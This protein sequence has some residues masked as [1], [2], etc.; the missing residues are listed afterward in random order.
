MWPVFHF[1]AGK[2]Q[3]NCWSLCAAFFLPPPGYERDELELGFVTATLLSGDQTQKRSR[4]LC[5]VG[6]VTTFSSVCKSSG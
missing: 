3:D 4:G 1:T 2:R 5:L 6:M